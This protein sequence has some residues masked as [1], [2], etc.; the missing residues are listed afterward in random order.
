MPIVSLVSACLFCRHFILFIL[1]VT[2]EMDQLNRAGVDLELPREQLSSFLQGAY[3]VDQLNK[4]RSCLFEDAKNSGLVSSKDVLVR[5]LKRAVGPPL[6]KKYADDVAELVYCI[7]NSRELPRLLLTNG[8]RSAAVYDKLRDRSHPV[9]I[10]SSTQPS[11]P[12]VPSATLQPQ[13]Q[14]HN[15][16][17]CY[18]DSDRD[19][20]AILRNDV[21]RLK[22]EVADIQREEE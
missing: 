4:I 15:L 9:P 21:T 10:N 12:I 20:C 3:S 13:P 6:G 22:K 2:P 7:K 18:T 1:I 11:A 16:G 5:R 8:K 17:G 14:R 19:C